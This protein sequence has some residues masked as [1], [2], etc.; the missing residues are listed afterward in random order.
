[1]F[2]L[3]TTGLAVGAHNNAAAAAANAA[4]LAGGAASYVA[5]V[6]ASLSAVL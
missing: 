1:M 5:D 2:G 4:E 3:L 6:A